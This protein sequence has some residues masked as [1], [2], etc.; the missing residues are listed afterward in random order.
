V[1]ND[2]KPEPDSYRVENSKSKI[3]LLLHKVFS[4]TLGIGYIKGGGSVAAAACCIC[5]CLAWRGAYPPV[6]LSIIITL[7]I[8]FA[9]IWSSSAVEPVWGKDP[10]RVVIDEVAG[11]C[12][13]LLFL[14]VKV[15]YL[16][17]AF[18]LFRFFDILKP[19]YIRRMEL[20]PAGWGIM[21][22]DLLAGLYTN[23]LL[24]AVVWFHLY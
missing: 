16:L 13:S 7:I 21:T 22:D 19:L 3:G 18:I 24:Q 11:M 1:R 10:S 2:N 9:G 14:P 20:L 12:I 4:S 15:K 5:W 6:L 23:I 8:T 17:C